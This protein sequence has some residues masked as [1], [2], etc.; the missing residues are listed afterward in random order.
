[1]TTIFLN[2][3]VQWVSASCVIKTQ[4]LLMAGK[5]TG[6]IAKEIKRSKAY[7]QELV[8]VINEH[9]QMMREVA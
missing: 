1:M 7:T 5:S 3:R 8:N 4:N 9:M 6:Q 2:G